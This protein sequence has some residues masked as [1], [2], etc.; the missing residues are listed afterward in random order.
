MHNPQGINYQCKWRL[1]STWLLVTGF[2]NMS[3]YRS[4]SESSVGK[5]GPLIM[6]GQ[7]SRDSM[8]L[9]ARAYPGFGGIKRPWVL[10]LPP[11]WDASPS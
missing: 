7:F 1:H 3:V 8:T 11:G 4:F 6:I 2:D 5:S 9:Q 10:L